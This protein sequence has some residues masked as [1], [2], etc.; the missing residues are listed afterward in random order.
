MDDFIP[1]QRIYVVFQKV[2]A[3]RDLSIQLS[4]FNLRWARLTHHIK[5]NKIQ[6]QQFGLNTI[7]LPS[8]TSYALQLLSVSCFKPF[9]IV[10]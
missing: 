10:F 8:H 1:I 9:K 2:G 6:A 3:R 7:S 5:S 4:P